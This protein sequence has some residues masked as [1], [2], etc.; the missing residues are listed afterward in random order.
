MADMA[1]IEQIED[2]WDQIAEA[3]ESQELEFFEELMEALAGQRRSPGRGPDQ[4][5]FGP[6]VRRRPNQVANALEQ[7][8]DLGSDQSAHRADEHPGRDDHAE[9]LGERADDGHGVAGVRNPAQLVAAA[10]GTAH[11]L[12]HFFDAGERLVMSTLHG[13]LLHSRAADCRGVTRAAG[14]QAREACYQQQD[15]PC[16]PTVAP[17]CIHR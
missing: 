15:R 4:K 13:L 17:L 9:R 12:A 2:A 3:M 11:G 6:H 16:S 7:V 10:A 14:R 1:A 5:P 8:G